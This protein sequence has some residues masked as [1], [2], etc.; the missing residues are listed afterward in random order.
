MKKKLESLSLDKFKNQ[1]TSATSIK[2][3]SMG[4]GAPTMRHDPTW[5][6]GNT[7]NNQLDDHYV[8]DHSSDKTWW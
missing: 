7:P 1:Q 3:G 2:G 5:S 6:E 8:C 4:D